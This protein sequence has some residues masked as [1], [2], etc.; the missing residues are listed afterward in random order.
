MIKMANLPLRSIR[1]PGLDNS[2][3]LIPN[4]AG[5]LV[6]LDA[7]GLPV[8]VQVDSTPTAGSGNPVSSGGVAAADAALLEKILAAFPQASV[9]PADVVSI[10]DGANGIPVKSLTVAVE[11]VQDLNGYDAPWPAGG[12]ANQ[13]NP[14]QTYKKSSGTTTLNVLADSSPDISVSVDGDMIT[15]VVNTAYRGVGFETGTFATEMKYKIFPVT[16]GPS[17]L[18]LYASYSAGAARTVAGDATVLTLAANTSGYLQMRFDETGTYV[19]RI[20]CA[21]DVTAYSPYENVCP[22]SGFDA[23]NV[24]RTGKNLLA[25]PMVAVTAS[26]AWLPECFPVKAGTY[27]LSFNVDL[28]TANWRLGVKVLNAAGNAVADD[29]SYKPTS[30]VSLSWNS[31][32]QLWGMGG[33][34][35]ATIFNLTFPKDCQIRLCLWSGSVSSSTTI[36]NTQ[37]EL[38]STATAYEPYQGN[39]YTITIPTAN[40]PCYG[41]TLTVNGDGTGEMVVANRKVDPND[42]STFSGVTYG[43]SAAGIPY[44]DLNVA[45]GAFVVSGAG[46]STQYRWVN[47]SGAASANSFRVYGGALTVYDYRF[48]DAAQALSLLQ[49]ESVVFIAERATPI[50][51]QLAAPEIATLLVNN[52]WSDAGQVSMTYRQDISTVIAKLQAALSAQNG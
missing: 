44:V 9:G 18:S 17:N 5:K 1:F 22:I 21:A 48:T 32:R 7:A 12:G 47:N 46:I 25:L 26:T 27:V 30:N 4:D 45:S 10:D 29:E 20:I 38:G 34:T 19:F 50:T 42:S 6:G 51:I 40:A 39:T 35:S 36:S 2:Y 52:V 49:S 13:F 15:V 37:L 14:A 41:G 8:S 3:K 11:P 28:N 31:A 33:N 16:N 43:T 24:S 23:V